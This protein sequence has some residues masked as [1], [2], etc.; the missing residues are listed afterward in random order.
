MRSISSFCILETH[1]EK[2]EKCMTA[3]NTHILLDVISYF[4]ADIP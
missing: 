3:Y 2:G 4:E 1:F